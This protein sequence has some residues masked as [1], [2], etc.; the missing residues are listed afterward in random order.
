MNRTLLFAAVIALLLV[1][2]KKEHSASTVPSG[3]KYAIAFNVS[4]FSA[5]RA[6]FSLAK[7]RTLSHRA[8]TL[9]SADTVSLGMNSYLDVLYYYVFDSNYHLVH[10]VRQDSTMCDRFGLIT[11]SLPNGNYIIAIAA[12]KAGLQDSNSKPG[13]QP[14]ST[15]VTYGSIDWKDTFFKR[16]NVSITGSDINQNVVLNR[17]VTKVELNILD[18]IPAN[19]NSIVLKVF[20]EFPLFEMS[21]TPFGLPDTSTTT[22]NIPPSAIGT[23]GFTYDKLLGNQLALFTVN[24]LCKDASGHVIASAEVDNLASPAN[25]KTILSGNLFGVSSSNPQSFTVKVDTA[26]GGSST[27]LF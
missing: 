15:Y 6:S 1:S 14:D 23:K 8:T 10:R 3:K 21:Q 7:Q 12:G 25:V 16:F 20:P 4:N 26:W 13:S 19:A 22:I 2:C 9:A 17:I 5:Y 27:I 24:I 18:A 11:D